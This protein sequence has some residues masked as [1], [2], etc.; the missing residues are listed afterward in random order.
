MM[1]MYK[2]THLWKAFKPDSHTLKRYRDDDKIDIPF[3]EVFVRPPV[4]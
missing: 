3:R 1:A 2:R 4:V